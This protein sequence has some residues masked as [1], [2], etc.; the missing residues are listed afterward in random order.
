MDSFIEFGVF[1]RVVGCGYLVGGKF[2]LGNVGNGG[3]GKVGKRFGDGYMGRSIS[4]E[5]GERSLFI[6]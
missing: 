4:I 1:V 3:S 6:Y 2:D 5:K